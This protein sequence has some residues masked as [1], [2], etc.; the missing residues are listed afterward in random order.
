MSKK[1]IL[2]KVQR[3]A[4]KVGTKLQKHSPEILVISGVVGM[5]AAAV[6]ACKETTQ[7]QELVDKAREDINNV[8]DYLESPE[9][10]DEGYDEEKAKK[11]ITALKFRAV[12]SVAK[13]YAPSV[14]LGVCSI[15]AIL[16]SNNILHKRNVALTA[17]YTALET[18]FKDYRDKVVE[19]FGE[20]VDKEL[21]YGLTKEIVKEKVI[22]ENGKEK[23]VKKEI[24]VVD[25]KLNSPYAKFFDQTSSYW[26]K[27]PEYNMMFL[28]TQQS[29]F[30]DLLKVRGHVFLNEIYDALDIPRTSIGAVCGW[31][32]DESNPDV[33]NFIDFGIFENKEVNRRFVNGYESVILLDFNCEGNIVDKI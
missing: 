7:L 31:V 20:Q 1:D 18:S 26:E 23:T 22:D 33:D 27:N 12:G 30:N 5:V 13:L 24:D 21:K 8:T 19:R 2:V 9:A 25:D 11:A 28:N 32:Y 6:M 10:K 4:N 29:Y 15:T 17:A 3:T 16:A 14:A